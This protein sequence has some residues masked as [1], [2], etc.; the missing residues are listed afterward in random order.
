MTPSRTV[1]LLRH[2]RA[3][4]VA[5]SGLGARKHE[6]ERGSRGFGARNLSLIYSARGPAVCEENKCEYKIGIIYK[7]RG[8]KKFGAPAGRP[9]VM[10]RKRS[11]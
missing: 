2:L 6:V 10:E 1:N 9:D 5:E 7:I 8:L 3:E 11:R 4:F